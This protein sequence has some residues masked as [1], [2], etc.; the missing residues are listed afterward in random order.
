MSDVL[1]EMTSKRFG[2][3]GVTDAN[4]GLLGV[5]TDGDLRRHMQNDLLKQ[6]A[7][8]VMTTSPRLVRAGALGGEALRLMNQNAVPVTC[9]FVVADEAVGE[10]TPRPVGIIHVHDCLRAGVA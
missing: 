2:C 5:I 9:L 8:Q 7:H 10:P 6:R 1:I 4:G 3:V